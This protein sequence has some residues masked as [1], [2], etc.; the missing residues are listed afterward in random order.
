MIL[1]S[2]SL[3]TSQNEPLQQYHHNNHDQ[4]NLGSNNSNKLVL[5]NPTNQSLFTSS[6]NSS[7]SSPART[8]SCSPL[9]STAIESAKIKNMSSQSI[10]S[11]N[12]DIDHNSY[13]TINNE[14]NNS[15]F[16][17]PSI[18]SNSVIIDLGLNNNNNI[19]YPSNFYNSKKFYQGNYLRYHPYS[20]VNKYYDQTIYFKNET[21]GSNQVLPITSQYP[22]DFMI[23]HHQNQ[24][25]VQ[26]IENE[27]IHQQQIDNYYSSNQIEQNIQFQEKVHP[28]NT[29][30][31]TN[32]NLSNAYFYLDPRVQYSNNP[33]KN[34]SPKQIQNYTYNNSNQNLIY[35][36]TNSYI[37]NTNSHKLISQPNL[38]NQIECNTNNNCNNLIIRKRP[39]ELQTENLYNT[40]NEENDSQ[41]SFCSI[42]S[43]LDTSTSSTITTPCFVS[44]PKSLKKLNSKKLNDNNLKLVENIGTCNRKSRITEYNNNK[45]Q[46]LTISKI[47]ITKYKNLSKNPR[48]KCLDLNIN[49]INEK[50]SEINVESNLLICEPKKRVSA[51]KKERRRTQSINN[52]FTD[53]RNR[54]PQIPPDT[55]LSKIKT[56]KLATEYIEYLMRCL[57]ESGTNGPIEI[58]FKP[59]LGKLRRECRSK[60]IKVFFLIRFLSQNFVFNFY[61]IFKQEVERKAKGRTGW[62]PDV[63]ATELKRKF[64]DN[65]SKITNND[66]IFVS[67]YKRK[68]EENI[69]IKSGNNYI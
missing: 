6:S 31:D 37:D 15:N 67:N 47:K 23:N 39:I 36:S 42:S 65:N 7:S 4:V 20:N 19:K 28:N 56:L 61:C 51:N 34:D 16:S 49:N 35:S 48:T 25:S 22:F 24:Q 58:S 43:S 27:N 18:V 54:I 50:D 29:Y 62:P 3:L 30:I 26:I 44:N 53:L 66:F 40:A 45:K 13:S 17:D 38:S 41:S 52:A 64:N 59:D 33:I 1:G 5:N 14:F 63:W 55:K 11:K 9:S 10:N 60:D 69:Q 8:S 2:N 57:Q 46:K 68:H 12:F 32:Q 21:I